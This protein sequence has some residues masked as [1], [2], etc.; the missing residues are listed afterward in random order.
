MITR[1]QAKDAEALT[2]LWLES[3]CAAHPFIPREYWENH[4]DEIQNKYLPHS[5]TIV[6]KEKEEP[7]GFLSIMGKNWIGALFVSPK[8]Q[9]RGIGSA[10][11]EYC[12]QKGEPLSLA[13][14]CQ[15]ERAVSFYHKHSFKIFEKVVGEAPGQWEYHMQWTPSSQRNWGSD[16]IL[17]EH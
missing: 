17:E 11:L 13:V 10:L 1:Y 14:Y 15:N 3:T 5:H 4:M 2:Q 12:K 8:A 16:N 6:W 7:L 9:N